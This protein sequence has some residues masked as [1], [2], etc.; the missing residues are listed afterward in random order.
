MTNEACR[1]KAQRR[2]GKKAVWIQGD[3]QYALV[4]HCRALTVTLWP[5]MAEAHKQKEF[6]DKMACGGYCTTNHEIIDLGIN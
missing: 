5:T 2:W 6:I 3:G 4:A 1:E